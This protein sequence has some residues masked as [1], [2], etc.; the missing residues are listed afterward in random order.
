MLGRAE[1]DDRVALLDEAGELL[2][3]LDHPGAG[4]VDD[5]EAAGL[6]A[7][8]DVRPDTVRADDHGRTVVDVVERLD[9]LD[10]EV[11][12]VPDHAL[13]VDDLAEGMRGLAG[14]RRLLGLVDRLAH[15]ITEPG[16]LRDADLL[17]GTHVPII[18]RA[19]VRPR[20]R[21]SSRSGRADVPGAARRCAA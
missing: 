14:G 16:P 7:L 9:G 21:G 13:V 11:L 18:P 17:D 3:L 20:W 15:A 10:A 1:D 2:L 6:G 8:H 4:A 19:P 12:Q 5:L